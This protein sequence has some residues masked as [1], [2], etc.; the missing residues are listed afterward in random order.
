MMKYILIFVFFLST[1]IKAEPLVKI[2][3]EPCNYSGKTIVT[4]GVLAFPSPLI[5]PDKARLFLTKLDFEYNNFEQSLLVPFSKSLH[6]ERERYSLKYVNIE[7]VFDCSISS[8]GIVAAGGFKSLVKI[9][10]AAPNPNYPSG[11]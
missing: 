8:H 5:E 1:A 4:A 2:L 6:A 10:P 9:V 11:M 7:G 3:V